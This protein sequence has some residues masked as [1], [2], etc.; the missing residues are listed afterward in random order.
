MPL[1]DAG[2]TFTTRYFG[3]DERCREALH[4]RHGDQNPT[5]DGHFK[6]VSLRDEAGRG[7]G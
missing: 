2:E 3:V 5:P 1:T 7:D 4:V 6:L